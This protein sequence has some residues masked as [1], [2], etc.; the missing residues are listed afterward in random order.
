MH[1]LFVLDFHRQPM[2]FLNIP[3]EALRESL[4][5]FKMAEKREE[6]NERLKKLLSSGPFFQI[7]HK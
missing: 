4:K 1:A 2:S 3:T 5:H 6:K 7:H